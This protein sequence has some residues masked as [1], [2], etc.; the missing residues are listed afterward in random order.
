MLHPS[1]KLEDC[2]GREVSW[3]PVHSPLDGKTARIK[4]FD[5][6]QLLPHILA[7][8]LIIADL[9]KSPTAAGPPTEPSA[10][11]D[12]KGVRLLPTAEKQEVPGERWAL[13]IGINEYAAPLTSLKYCARDMTV[14]REVLVKSGGYKPDHVLL[15]VDQPT[16]GNLPSDA[17]KTSARPT[18]GII[19]TQLAT[20]LQQAKAQDTVLFAFSGHGDCDAKGRHY[21][22]PSD[23]NPD[24]LEHTG[25]SIESLH[26]FL[27]KCPAKQ[28]VIVLDCCH[29]GAG[30]K[31]SKPIPATRFK[32]SEVPTGKG[33]VQLFSSE[34]DQLSWED[35]ELKQGVFS[36]YLA[37]GLRGVA[38]TEVQG[39]TDGFVTFSELYDY[40]HQNVSQRVQKRF[41]PYQQTPTKKEQQVTGTIVLAI[42][43]DEPESSSLPNELL[44]TKL[45]ALVDTGRAPSQITDSA[46]KWLATDESFPPSFKLRRALNLLAGE[47]I[48]YADFTQFVEQEIS[49]VENHAAIA[50]AGGSLRALVIGIDNYPGSDLS[51]AVS[52]ARLIAES[53]RASSAKAI[54]D[55][56]FVV[57]END[58]ANSAMVTKK[59]KEL[60]SATEK[61]DLLVVYFAG[62]GMPDDALEPPSPGGCWWLSTEETDKSSNGPTEV[63]EHRGLAKVRATVNPRFSGDL[64]DEEVL[65]MSDLAWMLKDCPGA[66]VIISDACFCYMPE[67]VFS[68]KDGLSGSSTAS[69]TPSHRLFVGHTT[70]TVE[71]ETFK[72]GVLTFALAKGLNGEADTRAQSLGE[73]GTTP[74]IVSAPDGYVTLQELGDFILG[75]SWVANLGK[76]G[77]HERDVIDKDHIIVR[78]FGTSGNAPISR[79]VLS[80]SR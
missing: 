14:L 40:V 10:P 55:G 78:S 2:C 24:L 13:L 28:K 52:D 59:I 7:C 31:S 75:R 39:N 9:G 42:R 57:L 27:E 49:Q 19:Y 47:K 44:L 66:I 21:L 76:L 74:K 30:A 51:Y 80:V 23:G 70:E 15:L 12:A 20:F 58:Q 41:R 36:Y 16:D 38:D 3:E 46:K 33:I 61:N 45:T 56:E 71:L 32:A 4:D 11:T 35:E 25:V 73:T 63:I 68:S 48:T 22:L 5:V 37:Q 77:R 64:T 1:L 54:V 72:H 43:V 50:N 6:R 53:L 62:R 29:S 79:S 67:G 8:V 69:E 17:L 60:S 18:S 34:V 65:A 26:Q